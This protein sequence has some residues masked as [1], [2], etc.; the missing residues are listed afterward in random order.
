MDDAEHRRVR[1]D[2]QR[3]HQ[4]HRGREDRTPPEAPHGVAHVPPQVVD[5]APAPD[6]A[7]AFADQGRVAQP[8]PRGAP[9][10]VLRQAR[11][12]LPLTLELQ[13]ETQFLLQV[14]LGPAAAKVRQ[15]TVQPRQRLHQVPP[16][17]STGRMTRPTASTI[18]SH[19]VAS[20]TSCRRPVSVR[21]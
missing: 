16:L 6:V 7:G 8:A 20:R 2:A 13:V 3:E 4:H 12:T 18:R 9:G 21:A 19:F 15:Q 1:A 17:T 14:F 10:V 5:P 11:V